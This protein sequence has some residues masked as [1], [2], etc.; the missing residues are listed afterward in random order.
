MLAFGDV[1]CGAP[2]S[3]GTDGAG[4]M[5]ES[6]T[7]NRGLHPFRAVSRSPRQMRSIWTR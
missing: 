6:R 4:R 3:S 5:M 2:K 1:V 7:V